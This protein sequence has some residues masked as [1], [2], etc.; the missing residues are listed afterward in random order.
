MDKLECIEKS[1]SATN[2]LNKL[3]T[4][5]LQGIPDDQPEAKVAL[6]SIVTDIFEVAYAHGYAHCKS[7]TKE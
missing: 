3:I 5:T 4:E 1:E 6:V 2:A 7:E